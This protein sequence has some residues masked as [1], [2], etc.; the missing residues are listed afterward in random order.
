MVVQK[1]AQ[2]FHVAGGVHKGI[3]INKNAH[4]EQDPTTADVSLEFCVFLISGVT[5]LHAKESRV[6]KFWFKDSVA[7]DGQPK[8]AQDFFK[9]LVTPHEFPRDYVGFIKKI[10]KLLQHDFPQL[11]KVEIE[12]KQLGQSNQPLPTTGFINFIEIIISK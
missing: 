12:M 2:D 5:G 7:R 10:M 8:M 6:L 3:I 1:E 4:V 9:N 11:K